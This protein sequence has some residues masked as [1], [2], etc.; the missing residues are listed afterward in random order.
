MNE[1][2]M[3]IDM[4]HMNV[5]SMRDTLS[6][7]KKP[8]INS[9]SNVF[10]LFGHPRN[11]VD[12]ILDMLPRNRGVLGLSFYSAFM[13]DGVVSLDTYI[14]QVAYVIHRIGSDHVAL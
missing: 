13:G 2:G 14:A 12:E 11:V 10:S 8:V 5:Q 7:S 9:H 6:L 1:L 3:M 4:A